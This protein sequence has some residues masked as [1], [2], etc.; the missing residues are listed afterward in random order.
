MKSRNTSLFLLN[1]LMVILLFT[2]CSSEPE[3]EE[4]EEETTTDTTV[5]EILPSWNEG[6]SK[7]AIID[8]V[9]KTIK[10]GS[11]DFIPVADRIAC[12]DN[13]GTLWCEQPLYFQFLFAIDRI[14]SMAPQH[15]EWK[16]KQPFKALLEGDIKTVMSGGEKALMQI[17]M[18]THAGMTTDEFEKRVNDW[19]STATHPVT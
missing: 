2:S 17:L 18:T 1:S 8:F 16:T 9:A 3:D 4:Y 13:D 15:P 11:A 14:K 19:M 7:K 12:F 6:A 5:T 10:E